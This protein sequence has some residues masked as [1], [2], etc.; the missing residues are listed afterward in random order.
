MLVFVAVLLFGL[1]VKAQ[2]PA[3]D[4]TGQW[5]GNDGITS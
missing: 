5:K 3:F 4:V 1:G 2:T